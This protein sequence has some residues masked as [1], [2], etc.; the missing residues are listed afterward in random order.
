[1]KKRLTLIF[2]SILCFLSIFT[3]NVKK[4]EAKDNFSTT[5]Y[6]TQIIGIGGELVNSSTAYEGV[7]VF[8]P[9]LSTP[10]DIFIDD[11]DIVYI[12]D[13]GNGRVLV[14]NHETKET[15]EIGKGV[16][17]GPTGVFVS[18]SSSAIP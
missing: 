5:P 12:A 4:V 13:K 6:T 9:G 17:A 14:Y 2:L 11:N 10:S 3:L 1:M 7:Y 16:L 15:K 8:N 18:K